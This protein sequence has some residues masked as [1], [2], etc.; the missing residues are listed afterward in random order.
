M[1]AG[2]SLHVASHNRR[3]AARRLD[4]PELET[5]LSAESAASEA[6]DR[7]GP[8]E[9]LHRVGR[10]SF[11]EVYRAF[12]PTLQ[13]HVALKLLLPS[14]LNRDEEASALLREARAMARVRHPNVVPIYGVDRHEGRVGFWSDFVNGQTLADLLTTQGALG[15]RE[16]ALVGIDV[17]R[18]AGAVHAAGFL[19]RD[20]K[21]GNVM[22]EEGGRILLMDFGLTHEHG[23]GEDASGTPAYMA[24]EL[25]LGE[26]AT[27]ASDVYA[28]G[29]MLFYL[30]TEHTRSRARTSRSSAR[31]MHPANGARCST[32]VPISPKRSP[33]SSRPRSARHP[34]SVSPAPGR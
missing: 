14:R 9:R 33:A 27:I 3:V 19:H 34:R 32:F 1:K 12:D 29:V 31:R 28:I 18:A 16:A 5:R 22:R 4:E 21:A 15:P 24:P 2:R 17:C 30:L 26:P 7:W 13:R 20:I 11:G 25:M 23:T 10:G 6:L 8:F